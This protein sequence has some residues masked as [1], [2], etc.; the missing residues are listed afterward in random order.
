Q[1]TDIP[2]T[3]DPRRYAEQMKGLERIRT[4]GYENIADAALAAG[5][6]RLVAQSIAFVYRPG[7]GLATEDDPVWTDASEPFKTTLE[8]TLAG[9][10]TSVDTERLEG[11]VLRY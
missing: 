8:A 9:E 1:L 4:E 11:L 5:A 10:R 2:Q 6:R 3:L 7:P